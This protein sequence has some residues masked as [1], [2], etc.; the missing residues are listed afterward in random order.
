M[1]RASDAFSFFQCFLKY[2]TAIGSFIPSSHAL[3]STIAA[4]VDRDARPK[5]ILEI[6]G[7]TGTFTQAILERLTPSD[8]FDVVDIN[9][10]CCGILQ[11]K[12]CGVEQLKVHHLSIMDWNPAAPYDVI[13]HGL[14]LN[15]FR[16]AFARAILEKLHSLL[17]PWG[18]VAYFEYA[19]LPR[20]RAFGRRV[21][22]YRKY[23]QFLKTLEMKERF[24]RTFAHSR[25][26]IVWANIPPAVVITCWNDVKP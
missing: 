3:A 12:F 24:R 13:V 2:P 21:L 14:P 17:C 4:C 11:R 10:R 7:G 23:K 26:E 1:E 16:P 8:T 20:L 5:R 18:K 9:P 15:N 22:N 6:G 25:E 19:V